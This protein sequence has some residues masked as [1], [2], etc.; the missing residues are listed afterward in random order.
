[1][2]V[3]SEGWHAPRAKYQQADPQ[4]RRGRILLGAQHHHYVS[5][6]NFAHDKV[7]SVQRGYSRGVRK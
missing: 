3:G 1:M 6:W 2:W 5:K 7:Q 4:I